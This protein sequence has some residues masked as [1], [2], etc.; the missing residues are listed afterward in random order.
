MT[1][2]DE[3]MAPTYSGFGYSELAYILRSF[4]TPS[5]ARSVEV[6]RMQD[7][8][9][10]DALCMAGA[11]SLLAH[12]YASYS[13]GTEF[14]VPAAPVAYALA[15]ATI[16]TQ[17][18]LLT[19]ETNDTVVHVESDDVSMLMQPRMLMSW[20]IFPQNPTLDGSEAVLSVLEEHIRQHPSGTAMLRT[21]GLTEEKHLLIRRDGESWTTAVVPDPSKDA[22][23][24][25]GLDRVAFLKKIRVTREF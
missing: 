17:I 21:F 20:F 9:S 24:T 18:E 15:N 22:V 2:T 11:S 1:S 5:S 14:L 3:R 4:D 19:A 23:E 6:L 10:D 7:E 13:D 8:V 12:D 25:T 16:W